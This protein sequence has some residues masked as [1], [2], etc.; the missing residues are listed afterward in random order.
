MLVNLLL[1]L[2]A[3]LLICVAWWASNSVRSK[4]AELNL[5][6]DV[7]SVGGHLAI[8]PFIWSEQAPSSLRRR[9]VLSQF[10]VVMA[11]CC[12]AGIAW[13]NEDGSDFYRFAALICAGGAI[14][15]AAW[16]AWRIARHGL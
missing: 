7:P 12:L 4:I 2:I 15:G 16:L 8:D 13:N 11:T 5:L 10:C 6:K 3:L 14:F 9:H 1:S